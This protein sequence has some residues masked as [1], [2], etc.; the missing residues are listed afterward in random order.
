MERKITDVAIIGAGPIG[1]YTA[2]Y[3]GLRD[4]ETLLFDSLEIMGGQVS[5][6]YAE[7]DIHDL[8]GYTSIR[9]QNFIDNLAEQLLTVKHLVTPMLSTNI[10]HVEK[11]ADNTFAIHSEKSTWYTKAIILA[12]G[13]GAFSPRPLGIDNETTFDNIHYFITDLEKFRN[14]NVAIFGGGDSAVDWSLMLE[15]IA[16]S[17]SIIHRRNEFRAK[18]ASVAHLKNSTVNIYTPYVPD[19][20]LTETTNIVSTI[21][22]KNTE[23]NQLTEL[24][25]DDIIVNYGVVSKLGFIKEW[26]E[27]LIE[28]NKIPVDRNGRTAIEGVFACGD[29]CCYEGRETQIATGLGEGLLT[30]AAVHRYVHPD[31]KARPIR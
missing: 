7:K 15:P 31:S 28:K 27:L 30:S 25:I 18:E 8:P 16:K 21:S 11:L 17:V 5:N 12:V 4:L 20:A 9:A 3:C 29:I 10:T 13:N 19:K 2:F 24:P 23:D 22:I 26:S 1:M 6:L 14:R